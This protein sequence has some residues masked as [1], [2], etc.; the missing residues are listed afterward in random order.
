MKENVGSLDQAVRGVLGSVLLAKGF[1][2]LGGSKGR[3][4]GLLSMLAGVSL[5]E[6]AITRVCPL[7]GYLGIDTRSTQEKLRDNSCIG[8]PR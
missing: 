7:S 6:S 3:S 1:S 2:R 4:L 5:I 8:I